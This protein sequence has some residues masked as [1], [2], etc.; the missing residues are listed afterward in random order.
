[1]S[2]W[3]LSVVPRCTKHLQRVLANCNKRSSDRLKSFGAAGCLKMD[4][5]NQPPGSSDRVRRA[6]S[7]MADF[8]LSS[9]TLCSSAFAREGSFIF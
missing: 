2:E 4:I 7:A 9:I 6:S 5:A 8:G 3:K 1:M